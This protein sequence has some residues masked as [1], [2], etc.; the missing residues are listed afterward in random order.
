MGFQNVGL[1]GGY[2]KIIFSEKSINFLML[3]VGGCWDVINAWSRK[4][5]EGHWIHIFETFEICFSKILD[6]APNSQKFLHENYLEKL[7]KHE[8]TFM[9]TQNLSRCH[10]MICG[11]A[12]ES[13]QLNASIEVPH[14]II[15]PIWTN[16]AALNHQKHPKTVEVSTAPPHTIL[17]NIINQ[18]NFK[19]FLMVS[20][21]YVG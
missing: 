8:V 14:D 3:K 20:R 19:F 6:F 12:S 10:T 21:C 17:S 1:G 5:F 2:D 9:S 15:G 4:F 11:C 18:N 7:N 13:L 16:V